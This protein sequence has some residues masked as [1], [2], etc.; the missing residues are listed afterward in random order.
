MSTTITVPGLHPDR[1]TRLN[2][3][4]LR[5]GRFVLYWMQRA[6]RVDDN[7]ALEYAIA[8]AN[9][10][11]LPVLVCF[12]LTRS[13]PEANLRH[14]AF[15]IE[16]IED[17]RVAL[18]ARGIDLMVAW[19]SPPDVALRA[20]AEAAIIVTDGAYLRHLRQWRALLAREAPC[21]VDL[22][23]TDVVVPIR[24]ASDHRE[25]AARTIRTK[26]MGQLAECAHLPEPLLPRKSS[27]GFAQEHGARA[28]AALELIPELRLDAIE[29]LLEVDR[30]VAPV[31]AWFRGGQEAAARRVTEFFTSRFSEYDDKRN[32]PTGT[33]TSGMSPYLHFGHVSPVR[34]VI[35]AEA[36]RSSAG[37][38]N[39]DTFVEELVV[40]RELAYNYCYFEAH[41]DQFEALPGWAR[42]TLEKHSGDKRPAIYTEGQLEAAETHD[43]YFNA[44]MMEMLRT[45][46]M[47]NYMRMYWGKKILEW[48]ES[49]RD[50]FEVTL[51]L[52]NKYF[53]DGRDANSYANVAWVYGLHDRPWPERPVF[54]TVR[55][56]TASGLERKTDIASYVLDVRERS[57]EE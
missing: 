45:G 12:G 31:T 15:L 57:T 4:E 54:G 48:M 14:Y 11:D 16:G 41:Y 49:P 10:L 6:Q 3:L 19:G 50:A 33:P 18:E 8:W 26:L 22:V 46:T 2:D 47:H 36:A 9:Q 24:R 32:H 52:N 20:G 7:H 13:Y 38:A 37:S 28:A 55:T 5:K 21:R 39:V 30:S 42:E 25:Y 35:E 29:G 53:L 1:V 56:M 40:R 23:E 34:L 27:R 17:V 51:R 44:A 43:D